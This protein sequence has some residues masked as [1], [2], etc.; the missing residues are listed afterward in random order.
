MDKQDDPFFDEAVDVSIGK[1]LIYLEPLNY[2]MDIEERTSI[3]DFKGKSMGKKKKKKKE[4]R[5][6]KRKKKK[7]NEI[8]KNEISVFSLSTIVCSLYRLEYLVNSYFI[9]LN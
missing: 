5:K 6:R 8:T 3:Y 1:A 9:S 7:K 4:E 2:L